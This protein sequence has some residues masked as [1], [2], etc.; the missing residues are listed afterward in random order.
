MHPHSTH[1]SASAPLPDEQ[2]TISFDQP[3]DSA[4]RAMYMRLRPD[5]RTAIAGEFIRLFSLS[6]DP[7]AQR[8]VQPINGMLSADQVAPMH[9]FARDHLPRVLAEVR[10]HP[11]T[12]SALA[13]PGAEVAPVETQE[14]IVVQEPVSAADEETVAET[15]SGPGSAAFMAEVGGIQTD[16]LLSQP[17]HRAYVGDGHAAGGEDILKRVQAEGP[18]TN[19]AQHERD[20]DEDS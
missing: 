13:H 15:G 6:R 14:A 20:S 12:R 8:F 9:I 2:S 7:E 5:Q 4:V 18:A 16:D 11:V 1:D 3:G 19:P 17:Q 10:E